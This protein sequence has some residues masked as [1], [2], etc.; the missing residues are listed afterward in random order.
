MDC[1]F[2]QYRKMDLDDTLLLTVLD[3]LDR[4]DASS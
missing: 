1:Y 3:V 2:D 4:N